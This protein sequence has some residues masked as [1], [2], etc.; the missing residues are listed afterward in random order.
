[1]PLLVGM[2]IIRKA[3][4][5]VQVSF[6]GMVFGLIGCAG[7]HITGTTVPYVVYGMVA[8]LVAY[9]IGLAMWKPIPETDSQRR[10][11]EQQG[12]SLTEKG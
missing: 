9:L 8:S 1:M 10:A 6:M 11:F 12:V 5:P 2:V 4:I 3:R 7:A